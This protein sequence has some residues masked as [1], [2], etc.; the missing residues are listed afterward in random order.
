MHITAHNN[1]EEYV[2]HISRS[3][4]HR[5]LHSC[6]EYI[7]R[8]L[9]L[10]TPTVYVTSLTIKAMVLWQCLTSCMKTSP[11]SEETCVKNADMYRIVANPKHLEILSILKQ[12]NET[13]VDTLVNIMHAQKSN[14]SQHL[15]VLRHARLFQVRRTGVN[16]F[17]TVTDPKIVDTC[18]V[19]A[20]L[21]RSNMI[22]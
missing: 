14:V 17:C 7:S 15:S 2:R 1:R 12:Y 13:T 19:L 4:F 21:R 18:R 10:S 8:C 22:P 6:V 20:N 9:P 16:A 11:F 5:V 3:H